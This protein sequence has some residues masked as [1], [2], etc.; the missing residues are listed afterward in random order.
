MLTIL[1]RQFTPRNYTENLSLS[2]AAGAE[3]EDVVHDK[4]RSDTVEGYSTTLLAIRLL[5]F[6]ESLKSLSAFFKTQAN[7]Q[8]VA[9][10]F[11]MNFSNY[12]TSF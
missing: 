6:N 1:V 4:E 5:S 2:I 9:S 8:A 7:G 11:K 10:E 3:P 12:P